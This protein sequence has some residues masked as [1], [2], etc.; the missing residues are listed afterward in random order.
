VEVWFAGRL[1]VGESFEAGQIK[2]RLRAGVE[3]LADA[4]AGAG[5]VD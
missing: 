4:R 5:V 3:G 2:D 1:Y